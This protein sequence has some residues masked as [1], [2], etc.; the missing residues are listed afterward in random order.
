MDS[1]SLII[2]LIL[3][4]MSVL[5]IYFFNLSRKRK[6]QKVLQSL[7][8]IAG[9]HNCRISAYDICGDLVIGW[10]E[11][12]KFVFYLRK[13]NEITSELYVDLATVKGCKVINTARTIKH[14]DGNQ[15][16]TEKVEL[17]FTP[18]NAGNEVKWEFYNEEVNTQLN[19]ELQLAE[20]WSK[21]INNQLKSR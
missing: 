3:L 16:V 19:T 4:A 20:K 9:V 13:A 14:K 8:N 17:S 18:L 1:N 15:K 5:P 11:T 10:D 21:L 2:G 12:N 7:N 6:Q